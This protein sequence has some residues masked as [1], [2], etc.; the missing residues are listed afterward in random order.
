M[1]VNYQPVKSIMRLA[2]EEAINSVNFGEHPV[3]AVIVKNGDLIVRSQTRT[4]RNLDP[5]AHAEMLAIRSTVSILKTR[6]LD[7]C[8]LYTTHEPCPMC[9]TAALFARVDGIVFGTSIKDAV[10]YAY[11]NPQWK[12]KWVDIS[13]SDIIEKAN[14]RLFVIPNFMKET[15]EKLFDL[16]PKS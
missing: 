12:W 4:H 15:C 2:I 9:A 13:I 10:N 6:R 16:V 5:S 11:Q 1:I 14:S 7:G 8:I 3:G